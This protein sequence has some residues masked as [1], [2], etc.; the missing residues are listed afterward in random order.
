MT[1]Q[2][3]V[4]KTESARIKAEQLDAELEAMQLATQRMNEQMQMQQENLIR[5]ARRLEDIAFLQ[6]KRASEAAAASS[7]TSGGAQ[8]AKKAAVV[9]E[10]MLAEQRAMTIEMEKMKLLL[11]E[12]QRQL[13]GQR[14]EVQRKLGVVMSNV[15][16]PSGRI[17]GEDVASPAVSAGDGTSDAPAVDED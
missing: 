13:M 2:N 7:S 8:D 15:V 4:A 14:G 17:G 11:Q 9:Q 5:E 10:Q 6:Q 3:S 16:S 1:S 12:Q